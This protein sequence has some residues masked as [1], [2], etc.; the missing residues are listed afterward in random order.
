[1][2]A[3]EKLFVVAGYSVYVQPKEIVFLK[4]VC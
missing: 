4:L 1:M 2:A 3:I